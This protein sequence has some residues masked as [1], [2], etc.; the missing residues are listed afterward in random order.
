MGYVEDSSGVILQRFFKNFP[1]LNVQMVGRLIQNK[2]IGVG[3]HQLCQRDPAPFPA[4]QFADLFE[5]VITC[6]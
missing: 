2:K 1:G 6:E 3:E 4:A 5:N